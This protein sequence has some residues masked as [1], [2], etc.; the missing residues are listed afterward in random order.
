M[1]FRESEG[2]TVITSLASARDHNITNYIFPCRMITCEVHSSLEAVGFIAELTAKLAAKG[3]GCNP[4]SGFYHDHLFVPVGRE[5]E[6]VRAMEEL[7][8]G[9]VGSGGKAGGADV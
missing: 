1:S 7:A 2:L 4:V 8:A 6:A 9:A 3:I 5:G